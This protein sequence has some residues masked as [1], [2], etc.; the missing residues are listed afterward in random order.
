MIDKPL[1]PLSKI[2]IELLK[3]R[4]L[5]VYADFERSYG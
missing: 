1:I 3:L 2:T 5:V 4:G